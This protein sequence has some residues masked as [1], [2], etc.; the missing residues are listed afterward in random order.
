MYWLIDNIS[1]W[2]FLVGV[3][4]LAY[5]A[6][7]YLTKR[8]KYL[9]IAGALVAGIVLLWFLPNWIV[10]DRKR[11]ELN[12]REM[13]DAVV[14]GKLETL[15][16]HMADDFEYMGRNRDAAAQGAIHAAKEFKIGYIKIWG[17]EVETLDRAAGTARVS[18]GATGEDNSFMCRC[19]AEFVREGDHW[20]MRRIEVFNAVANQDVPIQIPLR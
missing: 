1:I 7:Y 12:V 8:F 6:A 18:F 11:M 3:I 5:G 17:W 15:R 13:A 16:A 20:K 19:R 9:A 2:Q 10:T 14:N 4:A